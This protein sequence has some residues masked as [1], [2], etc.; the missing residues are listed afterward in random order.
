MQI[1]SVIKPNPFP[2]SDDVLDLRTTHP[3]L[4]YC[5]SSFFLCSS[6]LYKERFY[7]SYRV[8]HAFP[9]YPDD[10]VSANRQVSSGDQS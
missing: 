10:S 5:C 7:N 8:T 9:Y 1:A 2:F 4:R 3:L 6:G